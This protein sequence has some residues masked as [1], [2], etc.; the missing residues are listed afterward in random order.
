[1]GKLSAWNSESFSLNRTAFLALVEFCCQWSSRDHVSQHACSVVRIQ[2]GRHC[3]TLPWSQCCTQLRCL[4]INSSIISSIC[5]SRSFHALFSSYLPGR[6]VPCKGSNR[7]LCFVLSTPQ[8]RR[9]G[10]VTK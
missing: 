9:C 7:D 2:S 3:K 8:S 6:F 10:S 5:I 4:F 1:M